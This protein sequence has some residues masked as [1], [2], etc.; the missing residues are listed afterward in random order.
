MQLRQAGY[1]ALISVVTDKTDL[2]KNAPGLGQRGLSKTGYE[3]PTLTIKEGVSDE[4]RKYM[5]KG[6]KLHLKTT[7]DVANGPS[8]D[9]IGYIPGKT[10]DTLLI[11]S[12]IDHA[13]QL[14]D[15]TIYPG[16]LDNASGVSVM[17]ELARY[18]K[19]Q[20]KKPSKNIVFIAFNGEEAG[21]IGSQ[22]YVRKPLFPLYRTTVLNFD[23]I[24]SPNDIPL[25]FMYYQSSTRKVTIG[26]DPSSKLRYQL[27]RVADKM[28][29]ETR[30]T[31]EPS[32][33][34][35]YF[36]LSGVSAITIIDDDRSKIHTPSDDITN[37]DKKNIERALK[38]TMK[39]VGLVA[40]SNGFLSRESITLEEIISFFRVQYPLLIALL[41]SIIAAFIYYRLISKKT[42]KDKFRVPWLSIIIVVILT[43]IITYLPLR[44]PYA[45]KAIPG[46]DILLAEGIKS[47]LKAPI[48]YPL[49][50]GYIAPGILAILIVKQRMQNWKYK[51][52]GREYTPA[53]YISMLLVVITSIIGNYLMYKNVVY[54]PVT[55]DF[56]RGFIGK[57]VIHVIFAVAAY[58]IWK[59]ARFEA[60]AKTKGYK[61]LTA[62]ALIFFILLAAFYIPITINKYVMETNIQT[63]YGGQDI[64][65]I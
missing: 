38:L 45:S 11:T 64:N 5:D 17:L 57:L 6:Y 24:G 25:T 65:G 49:Y 46:W 9:V 30:E 15:G 40:Y 20:G 47:V 16:A 18:I 31:L 22:R 63:L 50:I 54:Y 43:G 55:P 52:D 8:A 23:M 12:H 7:I 39:Y 58:F 51:G 2:M 37:I 36:N 34:H 53:F 21:A 28:G 33:D 4:L 44:Y 59:L 1:Y 19:S 14:A 3:I 41:V 10:Q 61:S 42:R 60:G 62:F 32:S 48:I 29:I 35:V 27:A 13:G 26:N 56:A